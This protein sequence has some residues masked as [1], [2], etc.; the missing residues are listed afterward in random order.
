MIPDVD[1]AFAKLLPRLA[2]RPQNAGQRKR[3]LSELLGKAFRK[4]SARI[5]W[6]LACQA[7]ILIG[8][9]IVLMSPSGN[10][11]SF[12]VLGMQGN[13]IGNTVVMFKSDTTEA[14][15]RRIL[16]K[17]SARIVD[18]PT[19]SNSYVIAIPNGRQVTAVDALRSEQAV[20]LAELLDSGGSR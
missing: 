18:G 20:A 12:H 9:V 17:Y 14:E 1:Q 4:N 15:M 6:A 8:F 2:M 10:P 7:A 5:W 11:A 3:E 19:E 16:Q 13:T